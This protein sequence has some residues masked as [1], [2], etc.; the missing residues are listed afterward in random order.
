MAPTGTESGFWKGDTLCTL[1]GDPSDTN[2]GCYS[3]LPEI[4][5]MTTISSKGKKQG[6]ENGAG[7]G[8]S[9]FDDI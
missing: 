4:F 2:G 6:E 8:G 9:T 3:T 5:K 7:R 1:L